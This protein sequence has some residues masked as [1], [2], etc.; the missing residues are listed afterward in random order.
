[1][2]NFSAY[3]VR[4]FINM[5]EMIVVNIYFCMDK[6][7]TVVRTHWCNF[8]GMNSDMGLADRCIR[9]MRE[10]ETAD[11]LLLHCSGSKQICDYFW[12]LFKNPG[13]YPRLENRLLFSGKLVLPVGLGNSYGGLHS[14]RSIGAY[15]WRETTRFSMRLVD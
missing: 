13:A 6:N 4:S 8:F 11:H 1:M 2:F 12:G 10:E 9:C 15:G 3:Y 5:I 14:L 7:L